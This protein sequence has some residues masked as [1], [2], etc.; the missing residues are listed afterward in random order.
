MSTRKLFILTSVFLALLAFVLMYERHQPN[1]EEVAKAKKR[2]LDFKADSVTAIRV[3]RPDLPKLELKKDPKR[4]WLFAGDPGGPAD[5][6]TVDGLI[7]D[8]NRLEVVGAVRAEFDPKEFGLDVPKGK[9]TLT[10][11][12][13][14][15]TTVAFGTA[16]PGTDA[17]AAAEGKRFAAVKFA[18]LAALSKPMEEYRSKSL[19][20]L[21]AA[22]ITR[23]TV[24]K[25]PNTIIV[26]REM[27]AEKTPTEWRVEAP[28]KDLASQSFVEQLLSDFS[29]ARVSEFP[30]VVPSDLGKV[31]LQP[32]SAV[33]TLQK[34]AEIVSVVAF[35][36]AK[37]EATGKIFARRDNMVVVI[38]DRLQE[39]LGKEFSAYREAK[40]CPVDSWTVTR[41][42]FIAGPLRAGAE[43]IDGE[44]RSAGKPI[45]G[46]LA[47]DL[48]DRVAR[49]EIRGFVTRKDYAANGIVTAKGKSPVPV[50]TLELMSEKSSTPKAIS[51]F[52][53]SA[54][55]APALA[56]EVTGRADAMLVEPAL[57]DDLRGSAERLKKGA[58][59]SPVATPAPPART[60]IPSRPGATPAK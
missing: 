48:L 59:A 36:A 8:L 29:A 53:A 52:T 25:G 46:S 6:T 57:L 54:A 39:D 58:D 34:G 22:E 16:I 10:F 5:K 49:A 42:S 50:A 31:G 11:K 43:R 14:K 15:T 20:D 40:L 13:G 44:W 1:S 3:E 2:L 23:I 12:D 7:A 28:V 51:F 24:V 21:P 47:E 41:V 18:P 19:L 27:N 55:G 33:V 4:G 26:S 37:A 30:A 32:P 38:D 60:A 17:T 9:A 45:A 56:A 35:G